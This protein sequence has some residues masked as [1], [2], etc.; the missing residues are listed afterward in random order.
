[1]SY[2]LVMLPPQTPRWIEWAEA[3][4][5]EVEGVD[6]ISPRDD[7]EAIAAL[8]AGAEAAFGTL[9]PHLLPHAK[10]LQWL[11]CHLAGPPVG[12]YYPEFA[13]HP[14]TVTNL[15]GTYTDHVATHALML[16]LALARNLGLYLRQQ[17]EHKWIPYTDGSDVI[18][19]QVSTVLIL[20]VGAVGGELARLLEPFGCTVLA[21]DA[22]RSDVPPG[23]DELHP[24]EDLDDLLPRADFVVVTLPETPHTHHLI[25][26]DRLLMMKP[27]A[28]LINVG[29]GPVVDVD[30]LANALADGVIRSAAIDVFP[31]ETLLGD[32]PADHPLWDFPQ[33]IITPHVG[34]V[35]PFGWERRYDVLR[36]NAQRFA[37]G[38][39][40]INVVDKVNWF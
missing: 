21:T 40:L 31:T 29:R 2:T 26:A 33:M 23:V 3:I 24:P 28:S 7:E 30:A 12:Y 22:R 36:E 19:I 34:G 4:T 35:G 27:E 18:H 20:G 6:V 38:E 37:A 25:N 17:V 10:N 8:D 14:V 11:Q 15:R 39:P 9:P 32:M 16:V 1:M 13:D 5:R